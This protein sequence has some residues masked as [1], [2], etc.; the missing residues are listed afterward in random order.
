MFQALQLI[1]STGWI[2]TWVFSLF[3]N[4]SY[5]LLPESPVGPWGDKGKRSVCVLPVPHLPSCGNW[6]EVQS[7]RDFF[8]LFLNSLSF[9]KHVSPIHFISVRFKRNHR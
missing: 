1:S 5:A 3:E 9:V 6:L 2:Q 4:R 7:F 8:V